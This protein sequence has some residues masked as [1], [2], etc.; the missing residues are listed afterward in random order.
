MAR[1][2]DEVDRIFGATGTRLAEWPRGDFFPKVDVA[3]TSDAY[4]LRADLPGLAL[5]SIKVQIENNVLTIR[6]E[7]SR[8]EHDEGT[9]FLHEE[10]AYGSFERSFTLGRDVRSDN[11]TARYADG[12]L[13]VHVQKSDAQKMKE[14]TIQR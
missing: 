2:Q 5:E 9:N 3:E 13:E 14:I 4:V 11:V 10:R 7:R 8:T 12:V 1:L 6:G